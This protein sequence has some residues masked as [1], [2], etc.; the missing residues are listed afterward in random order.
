MYEVVGTLMSRTFRVFWMLEELGQ[1]YTQSPEP[2]RSPRV[3][4]PN[5]L[6]KV[7]ILIDNGTPIADSTAIITYLADKHGALTFPAGT[8]ERAAQDSFTHQILDEIDAALWTASRHSFILPEDMRVPD[9]KPSLKNEYAHSIAKLMA[10]K[11]G[12]FLMGD[13]ITIPDIILTHCGGWAMTAKFPT[14]NDDFKSYLK[15]LRARPAF[16][17]ARENK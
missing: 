5:P 6:G 2:P 1:P 8:L 12:P 16:Q 10:R 9:I 4:E 7:P 3:Q 14:D 17:K 11:R 13:Q 15:Q